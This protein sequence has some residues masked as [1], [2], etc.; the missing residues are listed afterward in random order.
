MDDKDQIIAEHRQELARLRQEIQSLKEKIARLEKNSSNSSKP[1]SSDIVKPKN[2]TRKLVSKRKRGGQH[3]HRKFTRKPFKPEEIDETIEYELKSKDAK[4]L[5]PLDEW[6]V[7][8]QI[9]LPKKMYKVIEH[10][11]RKY[12]NPATGKIYITPIQ[13]NL[14]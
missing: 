12:L 2:V 11:A 1:P 6:F 14:F 9:V 3:G 7:I 13:N 8:Q 5:E 4:G 10:K